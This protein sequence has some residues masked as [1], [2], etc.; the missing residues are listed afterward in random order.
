MVE[1][2]HSVSMKYGGDPLPESRLAGI[3]RYRGR[4][5]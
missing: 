1:A 2:G 5:R 4:M 3:R